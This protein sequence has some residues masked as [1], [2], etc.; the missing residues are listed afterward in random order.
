MSRVVDT[1]GEAFDVVA[2]SMQRL[3]VSWWNID[4]VSFETF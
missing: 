3:R 4:F 2:L 1:L